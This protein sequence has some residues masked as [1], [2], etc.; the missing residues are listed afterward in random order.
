LNSRN[1]RIVLLVT[2]AL[3]AAVVVLFG[4]ALVSNNATERD[5]AKQRFTDEA[6][7]SS[8]LISSIFD[9][10][11]AQ[12]QEELAKRFGG[13]LDAEQLD[14]YAKRRR[15]SYIVVLDA[16]GRPLATSTGASPSV[17]GTITEG[18]DHLKDVL[19]GAPWRLSG[20]TSGK[21]AEYVT[22]M[23][24]KD[25]SERIIVQGFPLQL[26]SVFVG[27]TLSKLPNAEKEQALV[28]DDQN[29]VIASA[30][31]RVAVADPAP[32]LGKDREE[33]RSEV[34]NTEWRVVLSQKES[35]LY[36]GST[37]ITQWLILIS[38]ALAGIVA[39][40]LLRRALNQARAIAHAN[41]ELAGANRDLER[42]NLE[43]TR[44][45][46]ELEQF[47]SVASHD[48]Q[49]PLRKVQ[50]FG[51]QLER[52]F[53]EDLPDEAR[54]YLHRMRNASARMSVLIEDLLRFSR[55]TTQAKAHVPVDLGRVARD[56]VADLDA[57]IA[58]SQGRVDIGPLPTVQADSTQMR[59][60]L[61]NLIANALKFRKPGV[62]PAVRLEAVADAP[63]GM[64]AFAVRDNGIG[65]EEN[66]E[67]R[68]FRVF[69]R[70]HPRD[71]YAG[72]GIGLALCRK[73]A[74]RHGGSIS[75]AGRP[76]DGATFTVVLPAA[77]SSNGRPAGSGSP[78]RVQPPVHA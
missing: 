72:T 74:E 43:L 63:P 66:Y 39:V 64:A 75:A 28:V 11:T 59:Q 52:R 35:D 42:V 29:R 8:A 37:A 46:G 70:L 9:S 3:I 17:L 58:E 19:E 12:A 78:A 24:A 31:A 47:A 76:G 36:A 68:I 33:T 1:S 55:V 41:A 45:N 69:E 16:E 7:V 48:L 15:L 38:L 30:G 6:K 56:V 57:L 50:T 77:H 27:N 18:P 53:A 54:D 21:A 51:D 5:A 44:S 65:F 26:I 2:S 71:I 10:T 4:Q 14:L 73:I 32:K 22:K 23:T 60:L 49:E 20:V 13:D 62:T 34:D 40:L 61:Q 67:E 25:G